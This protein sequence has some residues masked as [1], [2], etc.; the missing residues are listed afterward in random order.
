[1]KQ[2]NAVRKYGPKLGIG[3]VLLSAG[4]AM[5]TG[6][7]YSAITS[8][9]DF[10]TVATGIV[11]VFGLLALASVAFKGGKWVVRAIGGGA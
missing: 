11:A 7:D 8:A 1:M 6:A 9:V 10:A 3:A 5:A 2:M 4:S